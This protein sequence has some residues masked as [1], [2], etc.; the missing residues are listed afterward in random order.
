MLTGVSIEVMGVQELLDATISCIS[1]KCMS[2]PNY[3]LYVHKLPF[4]N[5]FLLLDFIKCVS[6]SSKKRWLQIGSELKRE[7]KIYAWYFRGT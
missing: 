5:F 6:F 4:P 2:S 3:W 1:E 7:C